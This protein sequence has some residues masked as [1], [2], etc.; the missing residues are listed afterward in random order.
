MKKVVML[1]FLLIISGIVWGQKEKVLIVWDKISPLVGINR[2]VTLTEKNEY[3]RDYDF[4]FVQNTDN[5]SPYCK[6]DIYNI[7]YTVINS[8]NDSFT[9]YCPKEYEDCITDVKELANDQTK[10]SDINNFVH[11][12]N[13]FEHIETEYD[14]IGRVTINITKTYNEAEITTVKA[15]LDKITSEIFK[16]SNTLEKNITLAH[17]YIINNSMYDTDRSDLD[18]IKYKSDTAYGPLLEG[19]GICGGYTDAME[20]FL[21]K[22]GVKSYRVSSEAH[23]WNA[24]NIGDDWYNLDLTWD[25]PVIDDGSQVLEHN[26]FLISTKKLL[27]IETEQHNFDQ[28]VYYE[29]KAS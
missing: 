28:D 7:F 19:Y 16:E 5:F 26:F 21:E 13:S 23:V 3:Y 4:D 17:D 6:Q 18:I 14:S 11:P 9:F 22:L 29:L 12:F 8:G 20:L 25:D 2:E 24:V 10:L 27:E 15:K 1:G